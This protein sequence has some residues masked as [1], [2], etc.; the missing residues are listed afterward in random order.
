M[1]P[2]EVDREVYEFEAIANEV[3]GL[4]RDDPI[5]LIPEVVHEPSDDD[6]DQVPDLF[7]PDAQPQLD[8][9]EYMDSRIVPADDWVPLRDMMQRVHLVPTVL[10]HG[11]YRRGQQVGGFFGTPHV[12]DERFML[13]NV[14]DE[15]RHS[16]LSDHC[17]AI[18]VANLDPEWDADSGDFRVGNWDMFE[19]PALLEP[20]AA[21]WTSHRDTVLPVGQ[22]SHM[23]FQL[24]NYYVVDGV[25]R[26]NQKH[27]VVPNYLLGPGNDLYFSAEYIISPEE[28]ENLRPRR[29]IDERLLFVDTVKFL[30]SVSQASLS[31]DEFA[32]FSVAITESHVQAI[33]SFLSSKSAL[34][35]PVGMVCDCLTLLENSLVYVNVNM[36]AYMSWRAEA[37]HN[38]WHVHHTIP[39]RPFVHEWHILQCTATN[40]V[41]TDQLEVDHVGVVRFG[42]RDYARFRRAR[43]DRA[44]NMA[45]LQ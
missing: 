36:N 22:G 27:A 11:Y 14:L 38:I 41:P 37:S 40:Q 43:H 25:A 10:S 44:F 12:R 17:H 21:R 28:Q 35:A 2:K 32:S 3:R 8:T 42:Q 16:V 15:Y 33:K 29:I 4:V 18:D 1:S 26:Y 23:V 5:V 6:E 9:E 39:M 34:A 24:K 31:N 20:L 45:P 13:D 7:D 19:Y 30:F